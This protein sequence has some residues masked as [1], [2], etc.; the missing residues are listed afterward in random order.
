MTP[1]LKTLAVEKCAHGGEM[2][3]VEDAKEVDCDIETDFDDGL[4]FDDRRSC[5]EDR[6]L[7]VE[8]PADTTCSGGGCV[9][10]MASI[11]DGGR[12]VCMV[13]RS[14][15]WVCKGSWDTVPLQKS[16]LVV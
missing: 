2:L 8:I 11:R 1:S 13:R 4:N 12:E 7:L 14:S 9:A 16:G 5:R 10:E 3:L 15:V 6:Q